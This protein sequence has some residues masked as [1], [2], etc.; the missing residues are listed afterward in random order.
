MPEPVV[1]QEAHQEFARRI[2]GAAPPTR[3]RGNRESRNPWPAMTRH[4]GVRG[5][6]CP[7]HGDLHRVAGPRTAITR[8]LRDSAHVRL[9]G[10]KTVMPD[11]RARDRLLTAGTRL[12]PD[13]CHLVID[14]RRTI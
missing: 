7:G 10:S 8:D 12:P 11:P 1:D 6:S 14:L 9:A 3:G 2:V 4:D 13:S 5:R